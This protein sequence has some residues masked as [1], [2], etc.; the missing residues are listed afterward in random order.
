MHSAHDHGTCNNMVKLINIDCE[1]TVNKPHRY[2]STI[3]NHCAS[4]AE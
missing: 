3:N 1:C 2:K 4:Q